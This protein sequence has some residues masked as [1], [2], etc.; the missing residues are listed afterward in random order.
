MTTCPSRG[1]HLSMENAIPERNHF[2]RCSSGQRDTGSIR[3][4]CLER[5][6]LMGD[7]FAGRSGGTRAWRSSRVERRSALV[8]DSVN[9]AANIVGNIERPIRPDGQPGRTMLGPFRSF[10]SSGKTV[11][12]DFATARVAR[13]RER[14]APYVV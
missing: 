7:Y 3:I 8:D 11:C 12:D 6:R 9:A 2:A 10:Y 13:T 1:C 4:R 5:L 14:L